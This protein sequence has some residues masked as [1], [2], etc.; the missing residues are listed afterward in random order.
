MRSVV[1]AAQPITLYQRNE[2]PV[3]KAPEDYGFAG[4]DATG[5]NTHRASILDIASQ[6][7][8]CQQLELARANL[9]RLEETVKVLMIEP[10]SYEKVRGVG[11]YRQFLSSRDWAE[12][13]RAGRTR[14][15]K[16][17]AFD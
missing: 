13:M 4:E 2:I 10:V 12:F 14:A 16:A 1:S 9:A 6:V 5:W 11:F 17:L 7:R 3:Q 15:R 8:T